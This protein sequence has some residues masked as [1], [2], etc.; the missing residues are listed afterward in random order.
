MGDGVGGEGVLVAALAL[1]SLEKK[2][3]LYGL[4]ELF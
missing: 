2:I 4:V 1:L 3:P